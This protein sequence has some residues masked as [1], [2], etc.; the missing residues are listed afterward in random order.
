MRDLDEIEK[1]INECCATGKDLSQEYD[2]QAARHTELQSQF[3]EIVKR[4]KQCRKRAFLG[5]GIFWL[6]YIVSM[7]SHDM[8]CLTLSVAIIVSVLLYFI[9]YWY[10]EIR[11]MNK[12]LKQR[13]E[14]IKYNSTILQK[15][16]DNIQKTYALSKELE[17]MSDN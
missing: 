14:I 11:A 1:E 5:I 4:S 3:Q 2:E 16:D 9:F 6:V 12:N 10:P 8:V 13:G 7:I 15:M 17:E